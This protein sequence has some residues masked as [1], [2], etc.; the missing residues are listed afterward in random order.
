MAGELIASGEAGY[1]MN[2]AAFQVSL[3]G[4]RVCISDLRASASK[5]SGHRWLSSDKK[6]S[7]EKQE[8]EFPVFLPAA[9]G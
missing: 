6:D 7:A 5:L 9:G 8:A 4:T 2:A 1:F 3:C